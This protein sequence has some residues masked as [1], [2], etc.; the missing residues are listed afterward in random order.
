MSFVTFILNVF[1]LPPLE[2]LKN[3]MSC[4]CSCLRWHGFRVGV[5]DTFFVN[6]FSKI[7]NYNSPCYGTHTG[8]FYKCQISWR[9]PFFCIKNGP[10]LDTQL[11]YSFSV[12]WIRQDCQSRPCL[13][14]TSPDKFRLL[15]LKYLSPSSSSFPYYS[16]LKNQNAKS[17]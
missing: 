6:I 10:N 16:Y 15:L 5:S 14:F 11:L 8:N 7:K 12:L 3:L 1:C 9:C 2:A 17:R 4:L 13:P